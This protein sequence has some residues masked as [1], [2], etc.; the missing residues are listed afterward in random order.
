MVEH[1]SPLRAARGEAPSL[2]GVFR[3]LAD[4]TRRAILRRLAEGEQTVGSLSAPF[5]MSLAAV[6][7]H[8][9]T[10]ERAGLV[11]RSV[12]GREHRL[13]LRPEAL[14]PAREW[15]AFYERFWVERLDA[16]GDMLGA[17]AREKNGQS[18]DGVS[19][20]ARRR[21]RRTEGTR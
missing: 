1:R 6:S 8:C 18:S 2:D 9:K 15:L 19:G 20:P 4:P 10:L 13:R 12:R 14:A 21:R 3:A 17:D 7:K 11:Q 16:L 5:S